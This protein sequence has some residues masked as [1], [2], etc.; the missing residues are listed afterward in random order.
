MIAALHIQ[1]SGEEFNRFHHYLR[2]TGHV[3]GYG[4]LC[5]LS[6][7]AWF[8]TLSER[9]TNRWR[10]VRAYC[11]AFAIGLTLLTAALDEWH[12]SFDPR[13]TASIRDVGLDVG[14]GFLALVL[15][16]LV[17]RMWRRS[18]RSEVE[19]VS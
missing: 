10:N 13:R 5:L 8:H 19:A 17:F 2:K 18:P 1:M 6:F 4:I 15:A 14:G 3:T 9:M 12:Q 11:A 16:I 7:R